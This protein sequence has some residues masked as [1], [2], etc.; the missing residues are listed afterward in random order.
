MRKVKWHDFGPYE[1]KAGDTNEDLRI[2]THRKGSRIK[3]GYYNR[4]TNYWD[5]DPM[6]QLPHWWIGI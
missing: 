5:K 4:M 6:I 3:N 1:S 2:L